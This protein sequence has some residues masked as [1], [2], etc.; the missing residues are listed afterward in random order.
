[1]DGRIKTHYEKLI[2]G[3]ID[4]FTGKAKKKKR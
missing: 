2:D 3:D 4:P 1:M